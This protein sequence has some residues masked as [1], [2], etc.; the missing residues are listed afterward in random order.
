MTE[1][2][3]AAEDYLYAKRNQLPATVT[4]D[5]KKTYNYFWK[6]YNEIITNYSNTFSINYWMSNK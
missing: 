6:K 4:Y 3:K 5:Y 1:Q 2:I